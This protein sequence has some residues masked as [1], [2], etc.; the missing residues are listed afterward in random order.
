MCGGG[1]IPLLLLFS[2]HVHQPPCMPGRVPTAGE[3]P[4][5]QQACAG[6]SRALKPSS[7]RKRKERETEI[8]EKIE[9]FKRNLQADKDKHM[10]C[11]KLC[12]ELIKAAGPL[13]RDASDDRRNDIPLWQVAL[14]EVLVQRLPAEQPPQL[15]VSSAMVSFLENA[16]LDQFGYLESKLG[17][18]AFA[19]EMA[20]FLRDAVMRRITSGAAVPNAPPTPAPCAAPAPPSDGAAQPTTQPAAEQRTPTPEDHPP[21]AATTP[22]TTETDPNEQ[23]PFPSYVMRLRACKD[24]EQ[25]VRARSLKFSRRNGYKLGAAM[26]FL[27]RDN[28]MTDRLGQRSLGRR[29]VALMRLPHLPLLPCLL[30]YTALFPCRRHR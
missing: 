30:S 2:S 13:P 5:K 19:M 16:G 11:E 25:M 8:E 22:T 4:Q 26:Y 18:P 27:S 14:L 23:P 1:V 21:R 28:Y 6:Q 20:Q 17:Q 10:S 12:S 3:M 24:L 9:N 7:S 15:E 29:S